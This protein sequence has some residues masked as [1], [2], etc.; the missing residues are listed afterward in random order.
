M[1]GLPA[2]FSLQATGQASP[3]ASPSGHFDLGG[4]CVSGK[5]RKPESQSN[6]Q[7]GWKD[8]TPEPGFDASLTPSSHYHEPT[9]ASMDRGVSVM[10]PA[11]PRCHHPAE[12]DGPPLLHS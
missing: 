6:Q 10:I 7:A 12:D 8:A 11:N 4:W 2:G 5:R 1:A 3:Q 9:T